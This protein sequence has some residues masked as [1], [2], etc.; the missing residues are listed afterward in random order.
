MYLKDND[1]IRQ[2]RKTLQSDYPYPHA[3]LMVGINFLSLAV[4]GFL[5]GIS[6]FI[7][8]GPAAQFSMEEFINTLGDQ[9]FISSL[10]FELAGIVGVYLFCRK[11]NKRNL[12]SLG[13]RGK[14]RIKKY[15]LGI[16]LGIFLFSMV[17]L[18]AWKSGGIAL[19]RNP[20]SI[21]SKT[22]ILFILGWMI[23]G[24]NE[25]FVCRSGVMNLLAVRYGAIHGI[26]VNSLIF[27]LLHFGNP[28]LS[29]MA[30]A[31]LFLFGVVCSLLFYLS[32]N[33]FLPAALHSF[34]NF[35][36]G[37]L[38]GAQVSG[39]KSYDTVIFRISNTGPRILNGGA[40]GL[41]GSIFTSLV[42][43]VVLGLLFWLLKKRNCLTKEDPAALYADQASSTVQ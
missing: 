8:M 31:N 10:F 2:T 24:F 36:Q 33:I 3:F 13:L 20:R 5:F 11:T 7:A 38:F 1:A 6:L 9:Y 18:L 37:N 12:A 34:W 25:E 41:E 40:F 4:L 17:A 16:I 21:S 28:G 19:Y 32:E 14:G 39:L 35:A 15:L 26:L 43:F 29:A 23:Q 30:L 22:F 27:S 42:L